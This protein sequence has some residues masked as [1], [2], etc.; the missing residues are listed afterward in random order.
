MANDRRQP[1]AIGQ[2]SSGDLDRITANKNEKKIKKDFL[3]ATVM[4]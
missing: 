2:L 3:K 1:T 4:G